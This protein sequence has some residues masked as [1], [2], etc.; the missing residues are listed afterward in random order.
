MT[1]KVV[2]G[3]DDLPHDWHS[4]AH[5]RVVLGTIPGGR[6]RDIFQL[7]DVSLTIF[8]LDTICVNSLTSLTSRSFSLSFLP[9]LPSCCTKWMLERRKARPGAGL[10]L[11]RS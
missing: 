2:I 6:E 8:N 7:Q 3:T 5:Y 4:K 9:C 11:I 1:D 10:P